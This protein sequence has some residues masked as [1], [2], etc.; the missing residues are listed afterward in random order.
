MGIKTQAA[1]EYLMVVG[2]VIVILLP[3]VY[4]YTK[5]SEESQDSVTNAK[6]DAISNE[7]IKATNQVYSYGEGSQ[8]IVSVDFPKNVQEITFEDKEIVFHVLNSKGGVS[9]IAKVSDVVL[10][11]QITVIPGNKKITIKSFGSG[12][13]VYVQCNNEDI[14]CGFE[15]ECDYHIGDYEGQGCRMTC[16]TN[17][18]DYYQ[19]CDIGCDEET[20][21]CNEVGEGEFS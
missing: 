19:P 13:S 14:R 6:I 4:L 15:W 21:E 5:Y 12:V 11:G 18:W 20:R 9:E 8:T 3:S 7:I 16:D 10:N 2:F 17:K 1:T